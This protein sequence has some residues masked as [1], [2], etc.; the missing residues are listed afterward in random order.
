MD[1][2][3]FSPFCM[4]GC[5]DIS[6]AIMANREI[7]KY[8]TE[9]M[10]DDFEV[11]WGGIFLH[12]AY[13]YLKE[14]E[15]NKF[16]ERM[17]SVFYSYLES[18]TMQLEWMIFSLYH[19]QYD[20]VLRELRN[21]VESAFLFFQVDYSNDTMNKSGNE[22]F[23][24]IENMDEH[25]KYGKKVFMNSGYA[26]WGN[27]Y[28]NIYKPLCEYTHTISSLI[29]N[30]ETYPDYNAMLAPKYDESKILECLYYL[31]NVLVLEVD[32][33]KIILKDIYNIDADNA[34]NQIFDKII[35]PKPR[36]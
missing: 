16:D 35:V 10:M 36:V 29:R 8:I 30:K 22:K 26:D 17:N 21:I 5:I 32:M 33:M 34:F 4:K 7:N 28:L 24:Y 1:E 25:S 9:N 11:S 31:Q 15:W 18:Q 3:T 6:N 23:K 20:L 12:G 14:V 19:G 13:H 27:V 2:L